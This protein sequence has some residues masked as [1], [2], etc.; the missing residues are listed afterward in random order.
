M[1]RRRLALVGAVLA[2]AVALTGCAGSVTLDPAPRANDPECATASVRLPDRVAGEDRR[3]T[4]AQATAAWGSPATV[5][6]VCG[7]D[8]PGP[9]VLPCRTVAGVDWI[10]DETE[11]PRYRVTTFNRDP[12]VQLYIDTDAEGGVSS[13]DVLDSLSRVVA[14]LPDNGRTCTERPGTEE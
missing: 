2:G 8:P 1:F 10:I 5:L 7:F 12:A 6:F 11:A 9:S 14:L 4:D 13:A 3:W